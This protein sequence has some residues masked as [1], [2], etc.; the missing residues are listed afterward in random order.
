MY[1]YVHVLYFACTFCDQKL[2]DVTTYRPVGS[3]SRSVA[4]VWSAEFIKV[5]SPVSQNS[6]WPSILG[7][8][9]CVFVSW[10]VCAF[11]LGCV[12]SICDVVH[13]P[14]STYYLPMMYY[15]PTPFFGWKLCGRVFIYIV[16]A[17]PLPWD[18]SLY[19]KRWQQASNKFFT[20][21]WLWE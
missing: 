1:M 20:C 21:R 4:M 8:E 9:W 16:S 11:I 14:Y 5:I 2:T 7:G 15:L 19:W 6:S 17:H 13:V 18:C 12:C 3:H 10:C